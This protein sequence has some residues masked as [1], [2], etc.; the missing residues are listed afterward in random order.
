MINRAAVILKYKAPFI[1]WV[2]DADLYKDD[3]GIDIESANQD[4]TVYL[5]FEDDAEKLEEW[6]SLN[7][8]QLFESELEDWYTDES[9]WPKKRNRKLFD[10]WF[11]VQCHSALIDTVDSKIIDDEI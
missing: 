5:I 8:K 9:L 2:N 11:E 7:F 3:L 4:R 6:I 1:K 10:E